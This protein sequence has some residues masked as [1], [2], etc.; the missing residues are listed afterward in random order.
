MYPVTA[1]RVFAI[2]WRIPCGHQ[3]PM[4]WGIWLPLRFAG[5]ILN[6][7]TLLQSLQVP[8]ERRAIFDIQGVERKAFIAL[9]DELYKLLMMFR[10]G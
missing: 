6:E 7:E 5:K 2:G 1:S 9:V 3:S 8:T 10:N 4:H